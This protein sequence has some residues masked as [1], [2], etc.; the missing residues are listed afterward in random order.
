[1]KKALLIGVNY[2]GT[3]NELTGCINDVLTLKSVLE[4]KFN[5]KSF[6]VLTDDEKLRPTKNNIMT[7]MKK[8]IKDSINCDE[9]WIHYSGHGYYVDDLNGDDADG[10][11]E[12]LVPIDYDKNGL[13]VDDDLNNLILQSKC[14]TR[15]TFDCCHS[16]SA[17]D[18]CYNLQIRNNQ[19]VNTYELSQL[20]KEKKCNSEIFMISGCMDSQTSAEDKKSLS[21]KQMGAMT[22]T[23]LQVLD[24]YNYNINVGDLIIQMNKMLV[25]GKYSQIPVFSSNKSISLKKIFINSNLT[26]N[27]QQQN[28]IT[29]NIEEK[30]E[31]KKHIDVNSAI[32]QEHHIKNKIK[33][34]IEKYIHKYDIKSRIIKEIKN[35]IEKHKK[36]KKNNHS[37]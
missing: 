1:M 5:Y 29:R 37:V 22:S 16:G 13:I 26:T 18:L 36:H 27:E 19:I 17:L 3:N 35:I 30:F 7:E 11:D 9:I 31:I 34:E 2:R 33:E 4:N 24:K 21:N 6:V 32:N 10:K 8:L 15:V 23:L 25:N 14:K 12:V 28:K 20:N